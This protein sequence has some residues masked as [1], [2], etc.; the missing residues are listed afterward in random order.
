M[1]TKN[2]Y[3][4]TFSH[5]KIE[6]RKK[7]VVREN[8]ETGETETLV[9]YE[10]KPVSCEFAIE[11]PS[12]RLGD[13]AEARYAIELS[14]NIK[15]GI[16]TKA[17]LTKQYA[18]AGGALPEE[19]NQM[20]VKNI[21]RSNEI[22]DEISLLTSKGKTKNKKKIQE[23]ESELTEIRRDVLQ[24]EMSVQDVYQHTADSRAEKQLILWY[25]VNLARKIEHGEGSPFFEGESYE[26]MLEDL[27]KKDENTDSFQHEVTSK[28]LASVSYWFY[29]TECTE[30][31]LDAF[32]ESQ[33]DG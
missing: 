6:K 9:K 18:D 28:F 26:E 10:D 24:A 14:K 22:V 5:D 20:V 25:T 11:K 33:V 12:R 31:D 17:M 7:E 16:V 30:E 27:Y 21:K 29:N 8:A 2:K 1:T 19:V 23:L 4:Y 3:I 32:L 13:E 15:N